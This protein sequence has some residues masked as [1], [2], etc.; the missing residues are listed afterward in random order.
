[1]KIILY[2]TIVI[3]LISCNQQQN[4]FSHK[5]K[6]NDHNCNIN[7]IIQPFSDFPSKEIINIEKEIKK[8]Y[9]RVSIN[10]PIDLPKNC[11]NKPKTRYRADSLIKFL[12]HNTNNGCV[13]IGLTTKD[14]STTKEKILDWG[15][16]GL[17]SC[18]GKSCV[19]ST[20]RIKG[21]NKFEKFE[22]LVKVAVH[23]LGHTQG[24]K[25]C[26]VDAC[27]MRDAKGKDHLNEEKEFCINCKNVLIKKGWKL[28]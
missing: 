3:V 7:I 24:L 4:Q 9:P 15:I 1:M 21:K 12:N 18:P 22:K 25:H 19:A 6:F 17:G 26:A 2:I 11:L 14:I 5:N 13:T 8:Y 27:L 10:K 23:E 28:I 20:F 16:F